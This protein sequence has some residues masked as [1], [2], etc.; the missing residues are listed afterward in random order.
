MTCVSPGGK[1]L[2]QA[3]SAEVLEE[4][5]KLPASERGPGAVKVPDLKPDERLIPSPP[6]RGPVA[7]APP[8]LRGGRRVSTACH[9]LALLADVQQGF[10]AVACC[11]AHLRADGWSAALAG[12]RS[13]AGAPG[14]GRPGQPDLRQS[15][16]PAAVHEAPGAE[17]T[18]RC[19]G[20]QAD[21]DAFRR[22]PIPRR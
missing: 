10:H 11:A 22:H 12:R 8:P 19:Y 15:A 16:M 21:P 17:P 3:P 7:R 5:R 1:L 20:E 2:G 9:F 6:E 13:S 18:D 4:F 14:S